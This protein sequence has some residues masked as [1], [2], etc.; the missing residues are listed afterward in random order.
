[1]K[2]YFVMLKHV[3]KCRSTHHDKSVK[4]SVE[5]SWIMLEVPGNDSDEIKKSCIVYR[6]FIHEMF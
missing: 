6:C 1:M 2:L 3:L 5:K 4:F